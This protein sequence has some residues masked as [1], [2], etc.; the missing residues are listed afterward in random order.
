MHL[1]NRIKSACLCSQSDF[2]CHAGWSGHTAYIR[3]A[4]VEDDLSGHT[5][6]LWNRIILPEATILQSVDIQGWLRTGVNNMNI[7]NI[8]LIDH[9]APKRNAGKTRSVLSSS[10]WCLEEQVVHGD[11]QGCVHAQESHSE[12]N[13]P[14]SHREL[15]SCWSMRSWTVAT[16]LHIIHN[17]PALWIHNF[18]TEGELIVNSTPLMLVCKCELVLCVCVCVIRYY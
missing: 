16:D 17:L 6:W 1:W 9:R 5:V 7:R 18:F 8:V 15:Y 13:T 14:F 11:L 4:L 10:N 3:V 2:E 12:P